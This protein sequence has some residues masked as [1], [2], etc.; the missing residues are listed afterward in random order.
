MYL[1]NVQNMMNGQGQTVHCWACY[2]FPLSGQAVKSTNCYSRLGLVIRF[3][4]LWVWFMNAFPGENLPNCGF[5]A[6][7]NSISHN[8]E[9]KLTF[10]VITVNGNSWPINIWSKLSSMSANQMW[11]QTHQVCCH[12]VFV[13]AQ[14]KFQ[15]LRGWHIILQLMSGHEWGI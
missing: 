12:S 4:R 2:F 9:D 3:V 15:H 10:T 13:Y 8:T 11:P 6:W 5:T 1:E 7:P 14:M